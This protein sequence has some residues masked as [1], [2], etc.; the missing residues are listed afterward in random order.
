[1]PGLIIPI[2]IA[3]DIGSDFGWGI[4][5]AGRIIL[6][7]LIYYVVVVAARITAAPQADSWRMNR[8]LRTILWFF[9]AGIPIIVAIIVALNG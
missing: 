7:V 6:F 4:T 5:T 1:M 9:V 8:V 2:K 3:R